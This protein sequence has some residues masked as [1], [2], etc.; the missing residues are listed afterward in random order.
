MTG[1]AIERGVRRRRGAV[2][3]GLAGIEGYILLRYVEFGALFHLFVHGLLGAGIALALHAGWRA[4]RPRAT[5]DGA[6]LEVVGC[7]VTGHLVSALP[8]V[9]FLLLEIP[10]A[11]WMDALV[12]HISIHFVPVPLA[13]TFGVF[14]AGVLAQL[15][16]LEQH[17]AALT[18][19]VAASLLLPAI[20]LALRSPLPTSLAELRDDERIALACVLPAR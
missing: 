1:E 6:G 20:G 10:H 8:D 9:A 13:L 19:A 11:P 16:R 5:P 7:A 4:R 17:R 2:V 18:T 3:A 15:A 12:A 14:G